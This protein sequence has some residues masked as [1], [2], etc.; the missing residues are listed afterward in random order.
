MKVYTDDIH[1]LLN[2]AIQKAE[3]KSKTELSQTRASDFFSEMCKGI[4]KETS[5][6]I[7]SET[8]YKQFYIRLKS[9]EKNDIGFSV[10]YLNTLS[11]YVYGKDYSEVFKV[12]FEDENEIPEFPWLHP[13]FPATPTVKLQCDGFDNLWIKDESYNITGVCKDRFAWEVYLYYRNLIKDIVNKQK[14]IKLPRLSII[15][16]GNAALSI[17][18]ILNYHGLP[19]LKVIVDDTFIDPKIHEA[20]KASGCEIY[21]HDLE[22]RKLESEEI[23]DI[24]RNKEGKDLTYGYRVLEPNLIPLP[25]KQYRIPRVASE[26]NYQKLLSS[27]PSGND[28]R[29]IRNKAIIMLLWD[30]GA[31]NGEIVSLDVD[32]MDIEKM[33]AVKE[34]FNHFFAHFTNLLQSRFYF[35]ILIFI[36]GHWGAQFAAAIRIH[37]L[38]PEVVY[39]RKPFNFFFKENKL[40]Q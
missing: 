20:L 24:T 26:E 16:S 13:S 39:F 34:T 12:V 10:D 29:H 21:Y 31:R 33:H 30:T 9:W 32:G 36:N 5:N 1:Q 2:L 22:N 28:P 15:S 35:Q 38:L 37:P 8:L 11:Q 27:I 7:N 17:Q 4:R 18:Y 3:K 25:P 14:Q 19:N 6:T 40:A 23:L